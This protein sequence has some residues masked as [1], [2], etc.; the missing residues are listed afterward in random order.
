MML[1]RIMGLLNSGL[2]FVGLVG[3]PG[4][5]GFFQI[6]NPSAASQSAAESSLSSEQGDLPEAAK[7]QKPEKNEPRSRYD[8][9]K[10]WRAALGQHN[11][12][13]PDAAAKAIGSWQ[14][15]DI[16]FVLDF[17]LKLALQPA[18]S[19]KRTLGK[20]QIRRLLDLN[21]QEVK[22]GDLSRIIKMGVLLHTDI[23]LLNLDTGVQLHP[24]MGIA[25]FADGGVITIKPE[26][27]HWEYARRL[28]DSISSGSGD[29]IARQ[30]YIGTTVYMQ[31]RRLFG[32]AA[33]NLKRGLE[34]FPSDDTILFYAGVLHETLASPAHQNDL[35]PPSMKIN[36]GSRESE[37]KLARHYFEKSISANPDFAQA[38]MGL[39]RVLG[40]LGLHKQAL[41]ELQQSAASLKDPQLLYYAS[42]FL[43]REFEILSRK[44]EARD[45][46]EFAAKL[47]PTAQ[48]PLFALSRLSGRSDDAKGALDAVQRAFALPVKDLWNDDP[49][50]V[51]DLAHV[52]NADA[53][54]VE[55]RKIFGRVQP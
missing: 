32:Y 41:G 13:E 53:L 37:L 25:F 20:A 50:W 26:T 2:V 14:D 48:S 39:G 9:V 36:Y 6:S 19:V 7:D 42:L 40:L 17:V 29:Q 1:A 24:R 18:G 11:P 4:L 28:L 38:H 3:A 47:Y 30:W 46:Y 52:R 35:M 27:C 31:S 44:N 10:E 43:G 5:P 33:Q 55:I 54:I 22:Q 12:G 8:R 23:A 49:W 15:T 16:E 45:Q 51:Y 34:K 21:D